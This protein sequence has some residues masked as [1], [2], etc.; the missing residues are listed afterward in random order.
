[1]DDLSGRSVALSCLGYALVVPLALVVLCLTPVIMTGSAVRGDRR[2]DRVLFRASVSGAQTPWYW[3]L[4]GVFSVLF[5]ALA[6]FISIYGGISM[7]FVI[8]ALCYALTA[9]SLWRIKEPKSGVSAA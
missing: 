9:L 7:S 8:G 4:N 1:M 6:V 2:P 3:A 5:S